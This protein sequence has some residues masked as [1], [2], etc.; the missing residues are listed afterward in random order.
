M[1]LGD[2][3][4]GRSE[5]AEEEAEDEE[6]SSTAPAVKSTATKVFRKLKK[7]VTGKSKKKEEGLAGPLAMLIG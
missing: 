3:S 4:D 2:E 6:D 7:T 1:I 5:A